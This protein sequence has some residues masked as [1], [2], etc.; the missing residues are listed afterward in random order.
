MKGLKQMVA[1]A[2]QQEQKQAAPEPV[3]VSGDARYMLSEKMRQWSGW[4]NATVM[5]GDPRKM[6]LPSPV[7]A[8]IHTRG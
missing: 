6:G 8:C 4:S 2:I 1:E 5:T 3:L 7:A